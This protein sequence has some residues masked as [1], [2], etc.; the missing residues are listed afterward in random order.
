MERV[1]EGRKERKKERRGKGRQRKIRDW[2]E[3]QLQMVQTGPF[4][5]RGTFTCL[6]LLGS[7]SPLPLAIPL[8]EAPYPQIHTHARKCIQFARVD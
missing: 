1:E 2:V 3:I 8:C 5:G 6:M 4:G 7:G